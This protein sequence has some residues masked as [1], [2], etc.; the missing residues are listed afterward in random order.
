MVTSEQSIHHEVF[1]NFVRWSGKCKSSFEVNFL[2]VIT[3][4]TYLY[5]LEP[6]SQTEQHPAEEKFIQ[7]E[8]PEF[9]E[10]YFEWISILK[11]V[12][13]AKGCFTMME[14]GAGIGPHLINAAAAVKKYHGKTFPFK[15]IGVE[16]EPTCFQ[17]MKQHFRNNVIDPEKHNLVEAVVSNKDGEVYFEVGFPRGYGSFIVSPAYNILL[18]SRQVYRLF[19][20][21]CKKIRGQEC[22]AVDYWSGKKGL[23][24]IHSQR[25][26]SVSLKTLMQ[27][28]D[29]VDLI[30]LDIKGEEYSVL[31]SVKEAVNKNVRCVHIGTHNQGVEKKLRLLFRDLSWEPVYDF[32]GRGVRQTPFGKI[33]FADGVQ[34]WINPK[35]R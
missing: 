29:Y 3:D 1:N 18:P 23:G 13:Q 24:N 2:G 15:L 8:Y 25:V 22:T 27:G 31:E 26:K 35:F 30:H 16:G 12:M 5:S 21:L 7:T 20:R 33:N 14:L 19:K 10:N 9:N 34:V 28:Y 6:C 32:A 17:W 4:R 11:S